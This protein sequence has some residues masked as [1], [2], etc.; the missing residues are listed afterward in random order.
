MLQ[1]Q[2]TLFSTT[3]MYKPM[4]TVLKVESLEYYNAHKKELQTRAIQKICV[5]RSMEQWTLKKNGYTK[6]KIRVYDKEKIEREKALR[7]EQIKRER[8][9]L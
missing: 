5:Q 1:L 8:G 4:S 2:F 3:G 7:Y 9:W 6:M